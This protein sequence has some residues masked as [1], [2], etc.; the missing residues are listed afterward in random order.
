MKVYSKVVWEWQGDKLVRVE[1]QSYEY[2]GPVALA[3]GGG[4]GTDTPQE[5]KD[6]YKFQEEQGRYLFGQFKDKVSPS[7]GN[8]LSEAAGYGSQANQDDAANRAAADSTAALT[9]SRL[10]LHDN[11]ASMGINPA[12]AR[13]AQG[14]QNQETQGAAMM[15]QNMT[16][17]RGNIRDKGFARMQDAIGMGMGT[18]TQATAALNSAGS[19]MSNAWQM[20]NQNQLAQAQ[21]NA[22]SVGALARLGTNMAGWTG[23]SGG[24][25][26][27]ANGGLMTN[28]PLRLQG[29][30]YVQR[31]N[32]GGR[33][34]GM[35][36]GGMG[37]TGFLGGVGQL[38]AMPAA[39]APQQPS[40]GMAAA[41][42]A[43]QG[44]GPQTMGGIGAGI[45]KAGSAMNSPGMSNFGAG[46]QAGQAAPLEMLRN[47]ATNQV[48]AT[49]G[50]ANQ[51]SS[52][53]Q[54]AQ[55]NADAMAIGGGDAAEIAAA[56]AA[57]QQASLNAGAAGAA[58]AGAEAA[59]GTGT[60]ALAGG[61]AGAGAALGAAVPVLGAGLAAY[62]LGNAMGWW[63]DGGQVT[64]GSMGIRG[65][66]VSGPG[67]P[68][69]DLIDAKLSDGEYVMPRGTVLK[70]GLARLE[71][72]R[73]D[74]LQY[75]K[76]MG[77]G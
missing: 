18:P 38:P 46:M 33:A 74:G 3:K 61:A 68:K 27:G 29:G 66:E 2:D 31:L 23:G 19:G 30:G 75:E 55:L 73:Q 5:L 21:Q 47:L 14:M 6:L 42:G 25:Q 69:D 48:D 8:W 39:R 70:Y 28:Q 41:Q 57:A 58:Q 60:G 72:M 15:A 1:E 76:Q 51:A 50:A 44:L 12:D 52:A 16:N 59:V 34:G 64:P 4:G 9:S 10:A 63:A 77:I 13:Y 71:K 56:Q 22:N 62:S 32:A 67:G 40:M 37:G 65:G 54:A 53:A 45:Q 24:V 36:G 35:A 49:M 43:A 20:Q 26:Y 17:A 7:Y 11:L